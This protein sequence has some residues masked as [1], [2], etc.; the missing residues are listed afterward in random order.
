M[1]DVLKPWLG[2]SVTVTLR[3]TV[4][5]RI[6]GVL[7]QGDAAFLVLDQGRKGRLLIPVTAVAHVA[8]ADAEPSIDA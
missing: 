2:M 4:S 6:R 5:V 7:T 3:A 8:A 1:S